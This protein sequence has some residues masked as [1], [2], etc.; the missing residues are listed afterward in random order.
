MTNEHK[1]DRGNLRSEIAMAAARMIAEEGA[2][3]EMAK[4]KAARQILGSGRI[5]GDFLPDNNE[6]EDEVRVYNALFMG[7]TQ[8]AR[9]LHLRQA[10]LLMMRELAQFTPYV[11]GAVL[12]GTAGE[13]SDIHLLLF[14]DSAKDIEIFL[15]NKHIEISVTE[16]PPHLT[17]TQAI[18]IIHF[19][20][21][22]DLFHL[23]I[24]TPDDMK[25]MVRA[26]DAQAEKADEKTLEKLIDAQIRESA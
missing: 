12:N 15:L 5:N 19:Y 25:K 20:H 9:L 8:P 13:H 7:D 6:I 23:T 11:T 22:N 10:A 4:R 26:T 3:Y 1:T 14:A 2:T 16:A 17:K 18:E 24:Y 21:K